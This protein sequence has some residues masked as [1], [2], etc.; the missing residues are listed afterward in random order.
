MQNNILKTINDNLC[1]GCGVCSGICPQQAISMKVN[2]MGFYE[3]EID[4]SKL[5]RRISSTIAFIFDKEFSFAL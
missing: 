4:K 5:R 3:P 1:S 2:S